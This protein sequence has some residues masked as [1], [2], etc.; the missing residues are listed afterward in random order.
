MVSY[1]KEIKWLLSEKY[2]NKLTTQAWE[3]IHKL[4]RG[5]SVGYLIGYVD[6][7]GCKIDLSKKPL[8][9][10][11]ETEYWVEQVTT[12]YKEVRLRR[13]T[14]L[15]IFAGSGCIGIT[16]LKHLPNSTVVFSDNEDSCLEQIKI[17]CE[18]N[19]VDPTRYKIIKSDVFK[20][21][22]QKEKFD[23]IF[24]NPPYIPTHSKDIEQS[25]LINEPATAL[26]GGEDGLKYIREFLKSAKDY[27]SKGG[28]IFM[29]LDHP[30]KN[31]VKDILKKHGYTNYK[32]KRDQFNK[33]RYIEK[34]RHCEE[35]V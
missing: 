5:E 18:L 21:I 16:I 28:R 26:F 1:K 32:F 29:E 24:A 10:R 30:Q 14:M 2:N 22:S 15:D 33:W 35:R 7:L 4:K 17:N 12:G 13:A 3:D 19:K 20:K 8:I 23:Y 9:P 11:P 6:F 31:Q 34:T 25:V 27:L